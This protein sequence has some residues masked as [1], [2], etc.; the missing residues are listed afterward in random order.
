[1]LDYYFRVSQKFLFVVMGMA[2]CLAFIGGLGVLKG[3]AIMD[4]LFL[5]TGV[6]GC[7]TFRKY[8]PMITE[9]E[10]SESRFAPLPPGM[11]PHGSKEL[12]S[13]M[14]ELLDQE[15]MHDATRQ[16]MHDI[17]KEQN[18]LTIRDAVNLYFYDR[19]VHQPGA[20]RSNEQDRK[21][22]MKARILGQDHDQ[23]RG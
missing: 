3:P 2:V 4:V 8:I 16:K 12:T 5:G 11:V 14:Y 17:L 18:M 19:L 9:S 21:E 6:W 10:V 1:M 22:S 20:R 13:D 15:S 7:L 23:E